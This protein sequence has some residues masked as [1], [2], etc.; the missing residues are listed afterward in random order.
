[1][2]A[3]AQ[4][5]AAASAQLEQLAA[6]TNDI[7]KWREVDRLHDINQNTEGRVRA[8]TALVKS[9][10]G[11]PNEYAIL[12]NLLAQAQRKEEALTVSYNAMRRWQERT[13]PDMV[14]LFAALAADL[15]RTD[16][17]S[18]T[19]V[20]W[21]ARTRMVTSLESVTGVL[22]DKKLLRQSLLLVGN[23]LAVREGSPAALYVLAELEAASGNPQ[24]AF[25]RLDQLRGRSTLPTKGYA[26][27]IT[28]ATDL[29]HTDK[30]L[31]QIAGAGPGSFTEALLAYALSKADVVRNRAA[32]EALEATGD[33]GRPIFSA[34]LALALGRAALAKQRTEEA[35]AAATST[36]DRLLVA[37]LLLDQNRAAEIAP[38]LRAAT[39]GIATL[40]AS[41][42]ALAAPL[43]LAIRDKAL[44]LEI[45]E[46][47][48]SASPSPAARIA[49]SRAL[50]LN[51]QGQEAL[52]ALEKLANDDDAVQIAR[53]EALIA[54]GK[55][56]D[57]AALLFVRA[58]NT[59]LPETARMDAMYGLANLKETLGTV[60]EALVPRLL[61]ELGNQSLTTAG[62]DA[63]IALV[64]TVAPHAALPLLKAANQADFS[65]YAYRNLEGLK[66]RGLTAERQQFLL[67]AAQHAKDRKLQ[68]DFLFE[69]M[70]SPVP[71][72][73]PL[74][75]ARARSGDLRWFYAYDDA[76][77]RLGARTQRAQA[78]V[79]FSS[80]SGATPELRRQIAFQLL[81]LGAHA[82]ARSI[83]LALSA[84][85]A[86]T[87]KDVQQLLFLWGP[88][89]P[90][91]GIAWLL[92]RAHNAADAERAAWAAHLLNVGAAKQAR[93]VCENSGG[94]RNEQ[95]VE[96][97]ARAY[98]QTKDKKA[99]R[100][101]LQQYAQAQSPKAAASL[102]HAAA[103][104]EL[105]G[106]ARDLFQ[107]Q[108]PQTP[109]NLAL[110][111]RSAL[112]DNDAKGAL[113]LFVKARRL[114]PIRPEDT[115][116]EAEALSAAK[117]RN[118]AQAAF[119]TFIDRTND[120]NDP[121]IRRLRVIALTRAG[122]HGDA[123]IV[124]AR[125]K[126]ERGTDF[127]NDHAQALLDQGETER[128]AALLGY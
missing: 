75:E 13:A 67:F 10:A 53:I 46:Q 42:L 101:L 41:E 9:G 99:L 62:R 110:A 112:A 24:S 104:L 119:R 106:I 58:G 122:M 61:N 6:R 77:K 123:Q 90:E 15:H 21:A 113:D 93:D 7:K 57:A 32:L 65:R 114:G 23:S 51:G 43:A 89:P 111:A 108:I 35:L 84:H 54:F 45:A 68:D 20:P 29:A 125:E 100:R 96:P 78:L 126:T 102:A 118:Q 16:L 37:Q 22:N 14:Q 127:R 25:T 3:E 40:P 28:L 120:A 33:A 59:L 94:A 26:L 1:L 48:L 92:A 17:I 38:H 34:R 128:A 72:I 79:E 8:L 71:E 91:E 55:V 105:H 86:P 44:A 39:D 80:S 76:L 85:A 97:L 5:H 50:S 49:W 73:L 66:Q 98:S 36:M 82:Q 19:L 18:S 60:P 70:K 12:A 124:V 88:R 63:R 109:A 95:C 64:I 69:L 121:E 56:Q 2:L 103:A 11:T 31:T 83:F 107:S 27:Y 81:E 115:F 4:I 52:A 30:A 47:W 116:Y 74:L 87:S 117:L